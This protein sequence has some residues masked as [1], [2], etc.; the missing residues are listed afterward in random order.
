M[1]T[2]LTKTPYL[3]LFI[4]LISIGVGTAS[5][6]TITLGGTVDITQIL[7]M[8]G[9]KI[10]NVGTPTQSSDAA[11]K[12]YVDQSPTTD[13]LALLGCTTNQIAR[14]DGSVWNCE[15]DQVFFNKNIPLDNTIT[16]IDSN[17]MDES[18]ITIGLD[19]LPIIS[20]YESVTKDLMVVHCSNSS[21]STF[22]T[23]TT[24]D[25]VGDFGDNSIT[26]GTDGFPVIAY[27]DETNGDL[28]FV[29]C[30]NL[31]CSNFDTPV[32]L[33]SAGIVGEQ[34]SIA[35]GTDGFPIISYFDGTNG[36]L[37]IAHCTNITCTT[38]GNI[39]P[40]DVT[41]IVGVGS[42]ITIGTDG[43]AIVAYHDITNVD[44]MVAHCTNIACT[45][46]NIPSIVASAGNVGESPS[47]AIGTDGLPVISYYSISGGALIVGHCFNIACSSFDLITTVDTED[48]TGFFTALTIGADGFPVIS[49]WDG[50]VSDLKVVHCTHI[51]CLT[52]DP[53]LRIDT[54]GAVGRFSS[55]NLGT[56][57]LPIISYLD[58]SNG[59]LKVA[60][61]NNELCIPN[62]TR[63]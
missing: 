26:I 35:I 38:F 20:Y 33:D 22:D 6:L 41:D 31:T 56:D 17:V 39:T 15:D 63:R 23:P 18:S 25:S 1:R 3:V 36:D 9:N 54:A 29:H 27:H 55:I 44:L 53:P 34:P 4:V 21:C 11:T 62:W 7:N 48:D 57:G 12:G 61:C 43:F 14:F 10:T 30:T 60:K 2:Q 37:K 5:A 49:Y 40:I 32:T 19:G 46:F 28:V 52:F 51:G 47:I 8:M 16:T 13:T 45:T 42:S 59:A 58:S 24:I 50:T